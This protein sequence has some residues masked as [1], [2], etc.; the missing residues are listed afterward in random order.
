MG[1]FL[2]KAAVLLVL[3]SPQ[4]SLWARVEADST[5][6]SAWLE[7]GTSYLQRAADYHQHK[8]PMTVDT[9]WAHATLDSAQG[10]FE[11]AARFSAGTRTADSARVYRIFAFG[12]MAYVD[13]EAGGSNSATLTWHTLPE[14]L[15]LPSVLEELREHGVRATARRTRGE[16]EQTA[17]RLGDGEGD[18]GGSCIAPGLR[19]CGAEAGG[20]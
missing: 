14:S 13:W 3:Q 16:M 8:K 5:D 7:L 17:A 4:Q 9:V 1:T 2:F 20:G 6:A 11:H 18:Q 10:A 15:R 19:V 12:E